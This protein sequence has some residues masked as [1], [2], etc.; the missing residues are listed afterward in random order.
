MIDD[1]INPSFPGFDSQASTF[2]IDHDSTMNAL[3]S[4]SGGFEEQINERS[5]DPCN[6]GEL[7]ILNSSCLSSESPIEIITCSCD[8]LEPDSQYLP[9]TS[10]PKFA[11]TIGRGTSNDLCIKVS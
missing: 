8:Y 4:G 2:P 6:W 7:L 10:N 11:F 5:S 9:T 1:D 3:Q